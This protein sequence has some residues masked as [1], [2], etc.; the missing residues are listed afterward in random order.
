MNRRE[1]IE[2]NLK[3]G[4]GITLF[5]TLMSSCSNSKPIFSERINYKGKIIIVGA[6]T[7]GL[8]AGYV[9]HKNGIDFQ[10]IEASS[11]FGGRVRKKEDFSDFPIDIGAEWIHTDP[12]ILSELLG[13]PKINVDIELI[14]YNPKK[15]SVV[16]NNVLKNAD[17]LSEYYSEHKFKKTTWFDYLNKY[18]VAKIE[19]NIVYNSPITEIDYSLDKVSVKNSNGD[20]FNGDKVLVTV[21]L[22]ILKNDMINFIPKWSP[23]R[24]EALRTV[25]MSP[26]L[27]V[28]IEF[29]EKF[30]PDVIVGDMN[31]MIND[32]YYKTFYDVA[33][34]KDSNRNIFGMFATGRPAAKYCKMESDQ[35]IVDTI[36]AELD[37]MFDGMA[38]KS[39]KKHFVQ[40][41]SN[42][43]F[44]QGAYSHF[45]G[46]V[47]KTVKT[48]T[49][50]LKDK[51]YFAGEA[52]NQNGE[53]ATVHGAGE[54]AYEALQKMFKI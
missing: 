15:I 31:A 22:S 29:S 4:L 46:S 53:T 45:T 52:F 23:K 34:K 6:G 3:L 8:F 25:E 37:L 24:V 14:E 12:S 54:S 32:G 1:F 20:I 33:Y 17:Y 47:N 43:Q 35:R 49:E 13:E 41:W 40:N 26:G 7:A 30:Y 50:P 51:V 2:N 16:E 10:I 19:H 38:S 9:L 27:K 21:P 5:P 18:V 28:F 44:I 36:V 39:Y 42:E 48:L 11:G